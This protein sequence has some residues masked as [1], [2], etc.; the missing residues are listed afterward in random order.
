MVRAA[1]RADG[2]RLSCHKTDLNT[3][4][5]QRRRRQPRPQDLCSDSVLK[6]STSY[7]PKIHLIKIL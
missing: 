4:H 6:H 7:L 5:F 3:I 1:A 2:S